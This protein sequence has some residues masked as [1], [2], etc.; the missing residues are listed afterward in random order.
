[1]Q[2]NT[3]QVRST[4]TLHCEFG[5]GAQIETDS[6]LYFLNP[7]VKVLLAYYIPQECRCGM[8]SSHS[9]YHHRSRRGLL[10]LGFFKVFFFSLSNTTSHAPTFLPLARASLT[11]QPQNQ[12]ELPTVNIV[13]LTTGENK[14]WESWGD[15]RIYDLWETVI[16]CGIRLGDYIIH[17]AL[18]LSSPPSLLYR[19]IPN[20]FLAMAD[21]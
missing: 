15:W 21:L 5:M 16:T 12:P 9:L 2:C 17:L 10:V 4:R 14:I 3:I 7:C 19:A 13:P 6:W 11:P 20:I 18:P 1:M 8:Y